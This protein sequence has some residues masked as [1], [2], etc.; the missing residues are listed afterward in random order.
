M[1]EEVKTWLKASGHSRQWLADQCGVSLGTVNNWLSAGRK[2][3]GPP[4]KIIEGLIHGQSPRINPRL[5]LD[6]FE[7]FQAL[8]RKEG[9][10][11]DEKIAEL[12]KGGSAGEE[13]NCG[14]EAQR[15]LQA[16]WLSSDQ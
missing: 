10:T 8:A 14:R 6:T 16:S 11:V 9:K 13:S 12:I 5:D 7:K 4:A 15:G 2:I 1:N 3:T